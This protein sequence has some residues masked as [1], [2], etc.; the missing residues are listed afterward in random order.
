MASS[1]SVGFGDH[2]VF[3]FTGSPDRVS[4]LSGPGTRPGIRPVI[5]TP[6]AGGPAHRC[7]VSCRL[8][9]TGIRFSVIRFPPGDWALLTVGLPRQ[10][11]CRDPDGVTAFRTHELRSGWAPS[12][13][14]GRWC[15]PR[16]RRL[17]AGRLPLRNGQS[18]HPAQALHHA[19]LRITRHQR[20]FKQFA[21]PIFPSPVATR[22]EQAA[23]GLEPRASHPAD[24]E[25]TTHAEEGTGHRARTRNYRSTHIP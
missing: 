21:R 22:M 13:P 25:P 12:V 1:L 8:S 4:T 18:L 14:R 19:G 6:P 7:M 3:L 11:R 24:Q 9:A 5:H 23:L 17:T 16:P 2:V 20:G 15:S 10:R